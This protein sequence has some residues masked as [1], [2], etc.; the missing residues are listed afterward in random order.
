MFGT[1]VNVISIIIG[2]VIG[3]A[4]KNGLSVRYKN[5]IMSAL[6]LS[7]LYVGFS[8]ALQNLLDENAHQ[9]LFLVS[10]VLGAIIG[11]FMDIEGRLQKFGEFI[12]SKF[13]NSESNIA[14]GF[15]ASTLLYCVGTMAILGPIN[16]SLSGDHSILYVKSLLDGIMSIMLASSLGFGVLLS[17][18][19]VFLYQ[20]IITIFASSLQT[21][22]TPDMMREISIIGGILISAIGLDVLEIK[23]IKIG[24][25]LPAIIFPVIFYLFV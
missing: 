20:G 11:E 2:S 16:S 19:S 25:M 24:N 7:A 17:A 8:G 4:L 9:I 23:T 6:G 12:E 14:K 5:I 18:F 10:L 15:V 3:L 13:K 21:I 22:I 1:I